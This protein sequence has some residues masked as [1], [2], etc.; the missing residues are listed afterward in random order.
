MNRTTVEQVRKRCVLEGMEAALRRRKRS[1]EQATVLDGVGEAQLIAIA[2]SEPP[3][4]R[5]RW[6]LHLLADELKRRQIV[7]TISHETVRRVLSKTNSSRGVKT[8][9]A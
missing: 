2:F 4:E 6:T 5:I 3:D 8:C 9:G 1:R 7:Q